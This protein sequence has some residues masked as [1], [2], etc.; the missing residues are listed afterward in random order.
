MQTR[1]EFNRFTTLAGIQQGSGTVQT[2]VFQVYGDG[3]LLHES[4]TLRVGDAPARIDVPLEG[5]EVLELVALASGRTSS[6]APTPV[7]AWADAQL[8]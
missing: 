2:V 1:G 7:V 8:H 3:R 4:A 6:G 5:V